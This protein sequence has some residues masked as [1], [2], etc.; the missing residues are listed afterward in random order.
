MNRC[1]DC[2]K[3]LR[4]GQG[5]ESRYSRDPDGTMFCRECV[6]VPRV[7]FVGCGASKLDTDEAVP[8]KDLYTSNYFALKREY[9]EVTCDGWFIVSAEHGVLQPDNEIEPYDTT[10]TDLSDY[11]LGKWS[12]RTS[13]E[14]SNALSFWNAYKS[15]VVLMGSSYAEHIEEWAFS[16][17]RKVERPFKE[18]SGIGEQMGLLRR[19]IDDWQPPGQADLEQFEPP[20]GSATT[21]GGR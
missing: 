8:A 21:D 7:A 15:A 13:N 19:E 14:I 2:E 18:T 10:I 6:F 1:K 9:A 5:V 4:S 17:T 11:E 3:P 20:Q 12:V 16:T